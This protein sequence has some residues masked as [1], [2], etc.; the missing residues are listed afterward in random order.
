MIFH[1]DSRW[2]CSCCSSRCC[3]YS[4]LVLVI[5]R[6][7]FEVAITMKTTTTTMMMAIFYIVMIGG[8]LNRCWVRRHGYCFCFGCY[9]IDQYCIAFSS[10]ASLCKGF[11]PH[12]SLSHSFLCRSGVSGCRWEGR[13][14][15]LFLSIV[16]LSLSN[17]TEKFKRKYSR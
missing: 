11:S 1:H 6:G 14:Y 12:N 8:R 17:N 13:Q 4:S 15:V 2:C 7:A 9:Q 10:L 5:R 3:C 16:R